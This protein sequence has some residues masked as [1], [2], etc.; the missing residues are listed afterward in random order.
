MDLSTILSHIDSGHMALP[1]FQRGYVWNRD[2]VRGLMQSLYRRYPVGSLLVWATQSEGARHRGDSSLAPGVVKL[3]LDGQQRITSLYGIIRGHA[4]KFFDGNEQAFTGLYFHLDREEFGFY[5]PIKMGD[6]PLWIDVSEVMQH[7]QDEIIQKLTQN[8]ATNEQLG[9]FFTRLNRLTGIKE[10]RFHIEEVAGDDKSIDVV[11]D[12]FNRV[13]SGGTKLSKGD[14]ALAKICAEDAEAR[15]SMKAALGRWQDAGLNFSLDWLLRSVNT[16][17]TGEAKF[18]FMHDLSASDFANGLKRAERGVDYLLNAIS[19][20]FGLDHDR[21]FFGRYAMPVMAHYLDRRGGRI[22]HAKELDKLLFWYIESAMWGRYSGSTESFVDRDLRVIEE[23]DGALDRLLQELSLWR[24]SLRVQPDHFSGWSLGARFYPMLYML[25]RVGDAR[26]WGSGVKLTSSLLGKLNALEVH[27]IFP[28]AL[29][30]RN[31]YSRSE[32][33]AVANFC[34]LTKDT[35]LQIS[36][37]DPETYFAE[38]AEKRPGALESQWIPV[39]RDLWRTE[40]YRDFLEARKRLLADATNNFLASLLHGDERWMAEGRAEATPAAA[41]APEPAVLGGI[42]SEEEDTLLQACNAWVQERSLPS[43]ELLFEIADEATGEPQA[44]LDLAWPDGL[45]TELSGPVALLIDEGPELLALANRRGFRCFT[46]V[47][48]FKQYVRAEI[49]S[50]GL[51]P[52]DMAGAPASE[53]HA[54]I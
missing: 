4:P 13:N 3:L 33:N 23:L 42:D 38:I 28:K 44:I 31:D 21:V 12:I 37:K 7:G 29:L 24:G 49:E 32:V 40:N 8:P 54:T 17:V 50:D 43:G 15:N 2:Q 26:D 20:R 48:A 25:T 46:S 18:E 1:E 35:N 30:Y 51:T 16:V 52:R 39:D 53:S 9:K 11:V 34:F 10:I 41:P 6:D 14:L 19:G 22:E 47:D 45:Q 5:S 27:H 36:D